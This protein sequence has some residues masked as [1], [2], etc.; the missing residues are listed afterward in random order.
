MEVDHIIELLEAY[1]E[2]DHDEAVRYL[3]HGREMKD[4]IGSHC[5]CC[6]MGFE[7]SDQIA[8]CNEENGTC[9]TRTV[10]KKLE[11]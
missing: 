6:N 8:P 3:R 2:L 11:G 5:K 4:V 7:M 9:K 10:L 1:K